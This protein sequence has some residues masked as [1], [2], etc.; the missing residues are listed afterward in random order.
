[1]ADPTVHIIGRGIVGLAAAFE[2]SQAGWSIV[3]HGPA[4]CPGSASPAAEGICSIKG[5]IRAFQPLFQ[6]K[7]AGHRLLTPWLHSVMRASGLS[8][9]IAYGLW[10]PFFDKFGYESIR[11]RVFHRKFTGL[12]PVKFRDYEDLRTYTHES[13]PLYQ[14]VR[15]SFFFAQDLWY[16]APATLKALTEALTLRGVSMAPEAVERILPH[17]DHGLLIDC[18]SRRWHAEHV[19][20]A[21]GAFSNKILAASGIKNMLQTP[22][23]GETICSDYRLRASLEQPLLI[24]FGKKNIVIRPN[25]VCIGSSARVQSDIASCAL[26][27]Q[28][29]AGLVRDAEGVIGPLLSESRELRWGIRGRFPTMGPICGYVGLEGGQRRF[30]VA[31]GFHKSGLQLAALFA[32]RVNAFFSGNFDGLNSDWASPQALWKKC[33]YPLN[34]SL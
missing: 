31:L 9:P 28:A 29:V 12:K 19:L 14:Q 26:N 24:N 33:G 3:M 17:P 27:H 11:T 20:L 10:E 16:D 13:W 34:N 5:N 6:A 7:M 2:L 15:G 1:M 21:A 18:A 23:E 25:Q 32:K 4:Q 30:V 22:V 8:I